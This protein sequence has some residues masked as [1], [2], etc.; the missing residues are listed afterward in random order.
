MAAKEI[1]KKSTKRHLVEVENTRKSGKEKSHFT[2]RSLQHFRMLQNVTKAANVKR[3]VQ[4]SAKLFTKDRS[5][6]SM[7]RGPVAST[8]LRW[9]AVFDD[10]IL[11]LICHVLHEGRSPGGQQLQLDESNQ[12]GKGPGLSVSI[13]GMIAR[14][15]CETYM[16]GYA[17][18]ADAAEP[19][20]ARLQEEYGEF[21][22]ELLDLLKAW[23]PVH[24]LLG[25]VPLKEG[26]S[27]AQELKAVRSLFDRTKYHEDDLTS[28]VGDGSAVNQGRS[29]GLAVLLCLF[30]VWCLMHN[31]ALSLKDFAKQLEA[32]APIFGIL[33]RFTQLCNVNKASFKSHLKEARQEAGLP[34]TAPSRNGKGRPQDLCKNMET[35]CLTRFT[36]TTKPV[37]R[38]V[39]TPLIFAGICASLAAKRK[40]PAAKPAPPKKRCVRPRGA[41]PVYGMDTFAAVL[42]AVEKAKPDWSQTEQV[43]EAWRRHKAGDS[44]AEE[45]SDDEH[46]NP[47]KESS[48][49]W[50]RLSIE[51][52]SPAVIAWANFVSRWHDRFVQPLANFE[53]LPA[54]IKVFYIGLVFSLKKAE[55][56]AA[57]HAQLA[58]EYG[59]APNMMSFARK[60]VD[61]YLE[62]FNSDTGAGAW[63]HDALHM[64]ASLLAPSATG[65]PHKVA[66]K[67]CNM[68]PWTVPAA[69]SS[70]TASASSTPV[71]PKA[72]LSDARVVD[73]VKSLAADP[74]FKLTSYVKKR[75]FWAYCNMQVH[76]MF[77]ESSFSMQKIAFIT[78][79]AASFGYSSREVCRRMNPPIA[80]KKSWVLPGGF[81]HGAFEQAKKRHPWHRKRPAHGAQMA[82]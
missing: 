7:L 9:D 12:E 64:M 38:Y 29:G 82:T 63:L 79:P 11:H 22:G 75:I 50:A 52:A 39:E 55:M 14:D 40:V 59:I 62:R 30:F 20:Q 42:A 26:Q 36:S 2:F 78:A 4:I 56:E 10:V 49:K 23:V 47:H 21:D 1:L 70:S 28:L 68:D 73:D 35:S 8:L 6:D 3:T 37:K 32:K 5:K 46:F 71:T 81:L 45:D 16:P 48:S 74:H 72:L 51:M 15:K 34:L 31:N 19:I 54:I 53:Q 33:R 60:A 66:V 24:A 43:A 41:C 69:C 80:V 17:T 13:F 77:A 76:S 44:I 25:I 57:H 65:F 61:A 58:N 27:A 18:R 67:L